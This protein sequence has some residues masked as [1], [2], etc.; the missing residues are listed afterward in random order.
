MNPTYLDSCEYCDALGESC[1]ECRIGWIEKYADE[2]IQDEKEG[3]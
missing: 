2:Q 3:R 1:D